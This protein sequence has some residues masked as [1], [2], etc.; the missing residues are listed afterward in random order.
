MGR[1]SV[2]AWVQ[3]AAEVRR[4]GKA[5]DAPCALCRGAR[6]PIDY[7]TQAEA[8]TD[9]RATGEWWLIGGQRPLALHVD[10][11]VPH[12]AGGP[13][14]MENSQPSHAVCKAQAGAKAARRTRAKPL[15]ALGYWQP[16]SGRAGDTDERGRDSRH[17]SGDRHPSERVQRGKPRSGGLECLRAVGADGGL[18]AQVCS[19]V[20]FGCGRAVTLG[21]YAHLWPGDDERAHSI[22]DA[23]LADCVPTERA[24]GE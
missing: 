4:L 17:Q 5:T 11:I 19:R 24:A 15:P 14:T 6:G 9:A 22:L 3:V 2:R 21:V 16:I 20:E 18:E 13:D 1:T 10:H 12:T 23:A 8:D 7:R